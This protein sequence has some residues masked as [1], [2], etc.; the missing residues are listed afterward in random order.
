MG[1]VEQNPEPFANIYDL[2]G[3]LIDDQSAIVIDEPM[4]MDSDM[5]KFG[6]VQV[7]KKRNTEEL[8]AT[9]PKPRRRVQIRRRKKQPVPLTTLQSVVLVEQLP[10]SEEAGSQGRL[11]KIKTTKIKSFPQNAT[12]KRRRKKRPRVTA[13]PS[14]RAVVGYPTNPYYGSNEGERRRL[15][16]LADDNEMVRGRIL[17]GYRGKAGRKGKVAKPKGK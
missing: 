14:Q 15:K 16:K 11:L 9:T 13:I 12:I 6:N 2:E 17:R 10:I 1:D 4:I 5:Q 7:R 8:P 3:H